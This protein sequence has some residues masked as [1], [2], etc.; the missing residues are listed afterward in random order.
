MGWDIG[1]NYGARKLISLRCLTSS[2]MLSLLGGQLYE[3]V[4]IHINVPALLFFC[5]LVVELYR[6]LLDVFDNAF[7]PNSFPHT[8]ALIMVCVWIFAFTALM[9]AATFAGVAL[10]LGS[11]VNERYNFKPTLLSYTPLIGR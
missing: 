4:F 6:A 1:S 3:L 10:S 8:F 9:T 2:I 7:S 5:S 11:T